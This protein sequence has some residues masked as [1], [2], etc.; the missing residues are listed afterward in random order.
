[1]VHLKDEKYE[2]ECSCNSFY[3]NLKMNVNNGM[4]TNMN[5]KVWLVITICKH[6]QEDHHT[7]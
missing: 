2:P 7:S 5:L 3:F 6:A 1:M 4:E